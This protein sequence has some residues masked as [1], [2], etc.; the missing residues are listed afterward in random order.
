M[1]YWAA[2][3]GGSGALGLWVVPTHPCAFCILLCCPA[4]PERACA[5]KCCCCAP[6]Q[7]FLKTKLCSVLSGCVGILSEAKW[8]QK[9]V[10]LITGAL[11]LR[12]SQYRAALEKSTSCSV[13]SGGAQLDQCSELS[14]NLGAQMGEDGGRETSGLCFTLPSGWGW[15]SRDCS[16]RHLLLP[17]HAPWRWGHCVGPRG[18]APSHRT[19]CAAGHT[20]EI[21][22]SHRSFISFYMLD[23]F[24]V[25]T[26][27][28]VKAAVWQRATRSDASGSIH[29]QVVVVAAFLLLWLS[30]KVNIFKTCTARITR[31]NAFVA[32]TKK[33]TV[34]GKTICS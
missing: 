14:L 26:G 18:C 19:D 5:A 15:V 30:L 29:S 24:Q 33:D 21:A 9:A 8:P 16:Y 20:S 11:A 28:V 22:G 7:L 12:H 13:R 32:K 25:F 2:L 23:H 31:G 27:N 6:G 10:K 34:K 4:P 1:L 17:F 3:S